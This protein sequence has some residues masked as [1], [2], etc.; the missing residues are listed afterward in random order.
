MLRENVPSAMQ[1]AKTEARRDMRQVGVLTVVAALIGLF[2]DPSGIRFGAL[3]LGA[4]GIVVWWFGL[5]QPK[6]R[7][8][9]RKG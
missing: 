1:R 5:E 9:F 8:L 4:L 2:I 3:A 6:L 7:A